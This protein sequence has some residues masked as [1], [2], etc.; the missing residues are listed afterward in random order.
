[1]PSSG[2]LSRVALVTSVLT[3]ATRRNIPEDGILHNI[4]GLLYI[5]QYCHRPTYFMNHLAPCSTHS[6]ILNIEATYSSEIL[7]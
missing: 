6:S 7:V 4:V 3:I 1:M 5:M 2:M